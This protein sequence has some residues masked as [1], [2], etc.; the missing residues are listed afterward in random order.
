MSLDWLRADSIYT[1]YKNSPACQVRLADRMGGRKSLP[2][3][4][5]IYNISISNHWSLVNSLDADNCATLFSLLLME[6]KVVLHSSRPSLLSCVGEALT[7]VRL[8]NNYVAK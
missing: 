4:C 6:Q 8:N 7:S 5:I 2:C 1:T 3:V